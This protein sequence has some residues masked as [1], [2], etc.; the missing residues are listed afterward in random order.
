M[1]GWRSSSLKLATFFISV[2]LLGFHSVAQAATTDGSVPASGS[3]GLQGTIS[4]S[5]PTTGATIS[6]PSNGSSVT[7][8]LVTVSGI[9][10]SNLLIKI[11]DNGIFVGSALCS[12]GSYTLQV[13]LFSGSNQ[14]IAVDYDSLDQSGPNSNTVT[15]NYSSP[16][17]SQTGNQLSLSSPYAE[18][19]AAPGTQ[20]D[21][22]I[23]LT[24]GTGPYA[25]SVDWG[26]GTS[27][28]LLSQAGTGTVNITHTYKV[29]GVYKVIVKATDKNGEEAFLQLVGQATGATQQNSSSIKSGANTNSSTRIVIW[30]PCVLML[31]LIFIAFWL[32]RRSIQN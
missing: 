9:C 13:D 31:P 10:P 6:V 1:K 24:G 11:F 4:S 29:S 7:Q 30:W 23:S 18:R 15:V 12:N 2:S 17:F 8:P 21:W 3:I 27:L 16:A 25:I 22:P 19:G 5:P 28:E 32:G 14:L 20:I 26:D